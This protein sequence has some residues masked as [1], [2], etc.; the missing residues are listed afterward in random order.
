MFLWRA[1]ARALSVGLARGE[2]IMHLKHVV[3]RRVVS[4]V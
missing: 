1:A 3:A 2:T 4:G